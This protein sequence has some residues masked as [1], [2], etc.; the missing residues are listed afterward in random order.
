MKKDVVAN[1]KR[2]LNRTNIVSIGYSFI[3]KIILNSS[4]IS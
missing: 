1:I 2:K 3:F 4:K